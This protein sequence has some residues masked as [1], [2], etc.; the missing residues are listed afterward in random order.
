MLAG[1]DL[2][3]LTVIA[4]GG[5]GIVSVVSN[6]IPGPMAALCAA[7]RA[8]DWD[9]ARRLHDQYLPLF[10]ANFMTV[11]PVPVKSALAAMGLIGDYVRQ[12]LLPLIDPLRSQLMGVLREVGVVTPVAE[13]AR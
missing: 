13:A 8:G 10:R 1:D 2:W 5:D 6:E 4:H 3:T 11:S 9:E 12:P 7:A